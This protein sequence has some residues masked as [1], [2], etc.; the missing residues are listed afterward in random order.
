MFPFQFA[1]TCTHTTHPTLLQ[2]K[3]YQPERRQKETEKKDKKKQKKTKYLFEKGLQ[4]TDRR[5]EAKVKGEKERYSHL[6]ADFQRVAR[7]DKKTFLSEQCKEIK[8]LIS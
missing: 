6:N 2:R 8:Y 3:F 7:R 4:I 1:Y 5:R